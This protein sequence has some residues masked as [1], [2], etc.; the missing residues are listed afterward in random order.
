MY[1]AYIEGLRFRT[2]CSWAPEP[3][4]EDIREWKVEVVIVHHPVKLPWICFGTGFCFFAILLTYILCSGHR[5][6]AN[7]GSFRP[8][9][10]HWVLRKGSVVWLSWGGVDKEASHHRLRMEDMRKIEDNE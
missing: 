4:E 6:H 5:R 2:R 7:L 1:I 3:D 9:T 10:P 8:K